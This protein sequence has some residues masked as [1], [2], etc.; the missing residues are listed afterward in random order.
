MAKINNHRIYGELSRLKELQED[1]EFIGRRTELDARNGIL[2]VFAMPKTWKRKEA[3]E[4]KLAARRAE[5][6]G[7]DIEAREERRYS[8]R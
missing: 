8:Y 4:R 2:T 3:K 6:A 5:L 1:Y 7:D